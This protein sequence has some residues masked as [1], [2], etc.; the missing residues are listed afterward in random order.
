MGLALKFRLTKG[1][2]SVITY[3]SDYSDYADIPE[4]Q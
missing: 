3:L 4:E 1:L 2:F